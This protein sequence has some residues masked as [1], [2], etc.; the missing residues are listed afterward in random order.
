MTEN[1]A[2]YIEH[3]LLKAEATAED[4]SKLCREARECKFYAVCI[5]PSFVQQA[6][7]ELAESEVK[8][9]TVIG[10]PLGANTTAVKAFEAAEAVASGAAEIDMV[11]NLGA[12]KNGDLDYVRRDISTVVRAAEGKT[13]KVIIEAVLLNNKEKMIACR[14]AEEAGAHFVKTST[15]FGPG[16]ATVTDVRL[17]RE[18]IG[19]AMGVKAAG[20]VRTAKDALLMIEAGACRIGTS[21][22]KAIIGK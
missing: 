6:V 5:N 8:V 13:V 14:L 19:P 18:T 17:M 7:K 20:G 10:F 16:G 9:A 12:L 2:G 22:G 3:T 1:M 11:I 4:I 21:A 15:G